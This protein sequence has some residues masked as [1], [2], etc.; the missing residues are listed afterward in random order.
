MTCMRIMGG[1][2]ICVL[3]YAVVRYNRCGCCCVTCCLVCY[4]EGWRP[5]VAVCSGPVVTL[6]LL[7][8]G[9]SPLL[10]AFV[11]LVA[12]PHRTGVLDAPL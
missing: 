10:A 3:W 7:V 11:P 5:G 6:H 4:P 12:L 8:V 1:C 9:L 2:M